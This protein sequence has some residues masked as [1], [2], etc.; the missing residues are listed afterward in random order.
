MFQT[1][2]PLRTPKSELIVKKC[3]FQRVVHTSA[4]RGL[5]S[6]IESEQGKESIYYAGAYCVYGMGL[7]EQ[8][9]ISGR[10]TAENVL[11]ELFVK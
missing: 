2:A 5:I 1:W 10:T 8:A 9:L 11:E 7:L 3:D 6:E 4:T